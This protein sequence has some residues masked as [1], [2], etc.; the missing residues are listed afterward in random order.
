MNMN[1]EP[2]CVYP[3]EFGGRLESFLQ[4][5]NSLQRHI[6][7]YN[8]F[9]VV[10]RPVDFNEVNHILETERRKASCFID[11]VLFDAK[12]FYEGSFTK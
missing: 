5:T 2:I 9:D 6:Q 4:L 8:D 10:N 1:T 3:S 11:E 12:K 7:D